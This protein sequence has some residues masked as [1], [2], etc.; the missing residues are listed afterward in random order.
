MV[1]SLQMILRQCDN[2]RMSLRFTRREFAAL[3]AV[4]PLAAQ[5]VSQTPQTAPV[6][7]PD[8]ELQQ[9]VANVRNTSK[10][11]SQIEVPMALE[12]AFSFHA[13]RS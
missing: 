10:Q 6:P 5:S 4:A 13:A 1:A 9:A 11:L 8:A 3:A 2:G 7:P 12:P